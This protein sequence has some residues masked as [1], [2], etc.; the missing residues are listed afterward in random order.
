MDEIITYWLTPTEEAGVVLRSV[1]SSL[2]AQHDAPRFEP[3]VTLYATRRGNEDPQK[4]LRSIRHRE[5]F[6]LPVSGVNCSA[7]FTKTL[8]VEFAPSSE[9]LQ[10]SEEFRRASQFPDGYELKP[11]LS[12][13]YKTMSHEAKKELMASLV[14]PFHEVVFDS[15][16]A[17]TSPP[18]IKSR[19]DVEAWRVVAT[20]SFMT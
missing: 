18:D 19:E 20:Q 15:V 2:A 8:F 13:I 14:L 1:I 17:V 5:R 6:R 12:L 10:L 3:H 9:L 16:K 11:H 7:R 4:I